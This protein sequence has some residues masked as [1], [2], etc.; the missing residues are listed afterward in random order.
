MRAFT[1][2][3]FFLS[4]VFSSL[5]LAQAQDSVTFSNPDI[6]F[7]FKRCTCSGSTAYIDFMV[8]NQSDTD[9]RGFLNYTSESGSDYAAY[10]TAAYDDEGN[11]YRI[12]NQNNKLSGIVI[13]GSGPGYQS[14][15][16]FDLPKGI[17]VK[18]RITLTGVD[19]Y[20][21]KISLLKVAFR[22]MKTPIAYGIALL[23][24][25]GLPITR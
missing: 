2:T 9:I 4:A 12:Q 6:S 19:E 20:A 25:R 11:V 13:G 17:P 10:Y 18:M 16:S 5:V 21:T 23:E 7:V 1:K 14:G 15:F 22:D 24:A 3:L 8:T